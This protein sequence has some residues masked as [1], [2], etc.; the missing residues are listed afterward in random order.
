MGK[1]V[2]VAVLCAVVVSTGIGFAA[3]KLSEPNDATA[4]KAAASDKHRRC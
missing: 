4:A 3:A 1:T 2:F